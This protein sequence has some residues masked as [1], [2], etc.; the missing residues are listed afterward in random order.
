[1]RMLL[2]RTLAFDWNR[3]CCGCSCCRSGIVFTQNPPLNWATG[4][5]EL[6]NWCWE[7]RRPN[8][9]GAIYQLSCTVLIKRGVV[10]VTTILAPRKP[11]RAGNAMNL[12]I[13]GYKT[14]YQPFVGCCT[15]KQ[16]GRKLDGNHLGSSSTSPGEA[17]IIDFAIKL[18]GAAEGVRRVWFLDSLEKW[19]ND[20][21]VGGIF[22]RSESSL[23]A[24]WTTV[25]QIETTSL[26]KL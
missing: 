22:K 7:N 26:A 8:I 15:H 4:L 12:K 2:C 3:C 21:M 17:Q 13:L 23:G 5:E 24:L 18:I 14:A 11:E 25:K 20:C 10:V 16:L 1:M 19:G 9:S 6:V